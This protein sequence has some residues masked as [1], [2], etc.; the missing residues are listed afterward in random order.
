[1]FSENGRISA[2]QVKYLLVLE[3]IARLG[4]LLPFILEGKTLGS[5]ICCIVIGTV[6]WSIMIRAVLSLVTP[7]QDFFDTIQQMT[8]KWIAAVCYFAALLFFL[9]Q[10]SVFLNLS[11]EMTAVYLLPE[12]PVPLLAV[13]PLVAAACMSYGSVEVRG[14]FCEAF[15]PAVLGLLTLLLFLSAFGMEAYRQEETRV[16]LQDHLMTG[17]LEVFA[18][19]G[20]LFLP[21]L[22]AHAQDPEHSGRER[23]S[24]SHAVFCAFLIAAAFAGCLCAVTVGSYGKNGTAVIKFPTVRMMSNVRVPGAF[25]QRWDILFFALLLVCMTVSIADS[26]WYVQ[27]IIGRLWRERA[28]MKR[29]GTVWDHA[30]QDVRSEGMRT[31][32]I[33][34]WAACLLLV[35][36]AASGFLNSFTA[37]C[38]YR[39][40]NLQLL[41]PFFLFFY[42][43]VCFQKIR[44]SGCKALAKGKVR[45][46]RILL[47][48]VLLAAS[49]VFL[50]GCTAREPEERMYPMALEIGAQDGE[51]VLTFAWDENAGPE[52][53]T[54]TVF[55][56]PTLDDVRR[57]TASF[58]EQ[59][60]DYS[61]VKA[62]ILADSLKNLPEQEKKVMR[63]FASE[64]AFASGL[65]VYPSKESDL[66]LADC[67]QRAAG[68]IGVY[69]ERLYKNDDAV[70]ESATTLGLVV[71]AYF[72]ENPEE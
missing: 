35:Y 64:P 45:F 58:T 37:S 30:E 34:S 28:A 12:V 31:R 1:M 69:L 24:F 9:A 57:Q 56:G 52:Q 65:L 50:G 51:L 49:A 36:A 68:Q 42:I 55:K 59:Y 10:A 20:G 11:A 13:L 54:L 67:A 44:L 33:W 62:I 41:I 60:M 19:F 66:T 23:T 71:A 40:L 48:V 7:G 16:Q 29:R 21:I 4:V 63:W 38:Y 22:G 2:R 70:R 39:A 5:V 53:N 25:L 26:L 27:E 46:S 14:R 3:W 47:L 72:L 8:G 17:G 61:H 18:C 15:G 43:V 6:L 32:I